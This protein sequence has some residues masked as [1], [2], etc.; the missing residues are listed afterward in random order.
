MKTI[1]ENVTIDWIEK[2]SVRARLRVMVKKVLRKVRL[3][4]EQSELLC[5][6]WAG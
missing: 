5:V 2:Q 6:D 3:S 1:R 4:T